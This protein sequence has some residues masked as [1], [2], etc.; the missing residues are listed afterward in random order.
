MMKTCKIVLRCVRTLRREGNWYPNFVEIAQ[1]SGVHPSD[2]IDACKILTQQWYLEYMYP[3]V[4]DKTGPIPPNGVRITIKGDKP[5]EYARSQIG[6]FL[7][8][9][10]IALLSLVVSVVALAV[11]LSSDPPPDIIRVLVLLW[12]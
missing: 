8:K 6:E 2:V 10:W 4:P 1:R 3:A 7:K 5:F 12:K 9:N 11:S